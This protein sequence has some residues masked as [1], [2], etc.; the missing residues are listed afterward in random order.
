MTVSTLYTPNYYNGNSSTTS[1]AITFDYND[2]AGNIKVTLYDASDVATSWSQGTQ[3]NVT[4]GNVVT[5]GGNTVPTGSRIA[6]EL[7]PDFLQ[8]I[9]YITNGA[10]NLPLLEKGFD[11]ATLNEQLNK[12]KLSRTLRIGG[13]VSDGDSINTD[14]IGNATARG[15]KVVGFSS[16][17]MAIS[18]LPDFSQ[19]KTDAETAATNAAASANSASNSATSAA[20]SASNAA[21]SESNASTSAST[22]T[23]KASEAS[24]SASSAASSAST[25]TT[26][27][28]EASISASSAST[29]ASSAST[30]ASNAST[31]ESNAATS[32]SSASTSASNAST[33]EANAAASFD[34]FDDRYLGA[35]AS[36]PALDNDG[37]A[38]I[39]G[40]LYFNS[41]S[42]DMKVW[43]SSAWEVA[44]VPSGGYLASAND[45]SDVA[46]VPTSVANLGLTIGTNVQAYSAVLAGT[47]ASYTTAEE[48]KLAGVEASATADQTNAEIET[49][50]NAQVPVV[51]QAVAEA[52]T[53]TTVS[54]WTPQRVS[55]AIAALAG[56][57]ATVYTSTEQTLVNSGYLTLAHGLGAQPTG[58]LVLLVCKT[59]EFGY[60][61]GDKIPA[62][63]VYNG[64]NTGLAVKI[65]AT[66][67]QTLWGFSGYSFMDWGNGAGAGTLTNANWKMVVVAWV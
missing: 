67:I 45:L 55:Q 47:T 32:A 65:D 5:T 62:P 53:A 29:S 37:N 66:N 38:L 31:S 17:G 18:L 24:T 46:S 16:D 56:G 21:T 1:F 7:S 26:K 35:K 42:G 48:T 41:T 10:A 30:S 22:A 54:R 33:S 43:N 25:A 50:Y 51:S 49:A 20:T 14:I 4:S 27:A 52:G 2:D 23:T 15:D 60:T 40:A 59:A 44:Y 11:T 61:V 3:Y 63:P 34:S 36:D 64:A 13:G 12:S 57:G 58:V 39:T 8:T 9:D 19:T 6:I 28:S